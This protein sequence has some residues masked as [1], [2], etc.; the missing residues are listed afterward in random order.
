MKYAELIAKL[1]EVERTTGIWL[2]DEICDRQNVMD[3]EEFRGL[4][5]DGILTKEQDAALYKAAAGAA[6]GRAEEAGLNL[7]KL[8]GFSLY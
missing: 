2:V 3:I 8:L 1:E 6:G 7:N 4:S 5:W